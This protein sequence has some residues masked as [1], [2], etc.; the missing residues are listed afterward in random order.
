MRL[1]EELKQINEDYQNGTIEIASGLT[2]SQSSMLRMIDFYTNSKF[3]NGQKDSKGRDK[4][5]YQII[6]TMVDTAVVATDIDTKDIKTE[7]DNETS[8]DKSFLFNHE[9]YNWMKETDF[10]QVLNEMGETRA[11]YGGVLVKKCREKGEEMKVEVVAWKNLVTDQVDIING[12][13]V[14]KHYMTPN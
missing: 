8:Y 4:P 10:A 9:I 5:F 3:L 12:V 6:N 2:F 14:E 7:A 11:R 13:I 1:I